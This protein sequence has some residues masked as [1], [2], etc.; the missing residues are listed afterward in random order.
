MT[1]RKADEKRL[2]VDIPE[3]AKRIGI[4]RN[5]AYEAAKSGKLP[6]IKI[7]RRVL[8]PIVGLDRF[9]RGEVA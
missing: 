6:T 1:N 7:G 8:V 2:T 9:L 3:A 5:Q 4:G